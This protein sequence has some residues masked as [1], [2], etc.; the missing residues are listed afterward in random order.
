MKKL[1]I[2]VK[3]RYLRIGLR[4][5]AITLCLAMLAFV[6]KAYAQVA[7]HAGVIAK[8]TVLISAGFILPEGGESYIKEKYEE[9]KKPPTTVPATQSTTEAAVTTT[10]VPATEAATTTASTAAAPA[11]TLKVNERQIKNTGLNYGSVW[12]KK[13]T[14]NKTIDVKTELE[15]APQVKIKKNTDEPQV[16]I[17][18]THTTEGYMSEYTG[19]YSKD[20][21]PRT[22]D[23]SKSV[24][25]VGDIITEKLNAEGIKTLHCTTYHDYPKYNGSYTRTEKTIKEY[26]QKYPSI[27]AV[28]DVHRDAM[29]DSDGTKTK[30]TA[31]INGKK[32][33][34]VMIISGCDDEDKLSFPEW[35][36]N[37]RLAVRIQKE[38][39]E[40][41]PGLARP[42]LFPPFRYNMHLTKGSLIIEF[43]TDA[44]T[45]EEAQY[46]GGMVGEC[47][48]NVLGRLS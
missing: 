27:Q 44:N 48:A 14:N 30:P 31:T 1:K 46:S 43:G 24:V 6:P 34:Q 12:V 10:A 2:K 35:E 4:L 5:S 16:L 40:K 20:F 36:K 19:T 22:T 9:S 25:S 33:A 38:M 28:I 29:Q 3:R 15:R 13:Q 37:M 21:N 23:K 32:A 18:H 11:G 41:Y 47:L 45:L 26:L 39:A 8:E 7:P 42:I 17:V